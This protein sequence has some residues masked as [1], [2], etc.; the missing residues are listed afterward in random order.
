MP[1]SHPSASASA[2]QSGVTLEPRGRRGE[3]PALSA[4]VKERFQKRVSNG[5]KR[6]SQSNS[7]DGAAAGLLL[8]ASKPDLTSHPRSCSST[9]DD[10]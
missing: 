4:H 8:C 9:F 5:I 1:F 7:Q 6:A 10:N 3:S 2:K